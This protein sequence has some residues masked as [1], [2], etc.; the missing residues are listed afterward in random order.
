MNT[1]YS[2]TL[3]IGIVFIYLFDTLMGIEIKTHSVGIEHFIKLSIH[4]CL[5]I[6]LGGCIHFLF[7]KK[8]T[9]KERGGKI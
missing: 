2:L 7:K 9:K 3:F 6:V 1:K 8:N 4:D 5:W